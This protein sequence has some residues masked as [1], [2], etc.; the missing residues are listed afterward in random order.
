MILVTGANGFVGKAL[1]DHLK[2]LDFKVKG[3]QRA[4]TSCGKE[5]DFVQI[6]V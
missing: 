2:I 4:L 1:I 5:E 6:F 3:S